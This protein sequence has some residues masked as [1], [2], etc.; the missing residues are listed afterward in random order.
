MSNTAQD[1]Q[2]E[3]DEL[4]RRLALARQMGGAEK[5][6]RQHAQGKLDVRQRIEQLLDDGSFHEIDLSYLV[7]YVSTFCRLQ[8]G[9]SISTG[10]PGGIGARRSPPRFMKAGDVIE[11]EVSGIGVLRNVVVDESLS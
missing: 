8:P 11:V 6:A 5:V 7:H 2:P 1:W 10:T 4:A 9:D 3:L